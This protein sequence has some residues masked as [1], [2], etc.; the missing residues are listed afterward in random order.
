VEKSIN[1]AIHT[2]ADRISQRLTGRI[3]ELAERYE[4]PLP[5]LEKTVKELEEESKCSS[6]KN[7]VCMVIINNKINGFAFIMK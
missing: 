3:K 5:E 6:G 7:G 4:T 2:E 1:K